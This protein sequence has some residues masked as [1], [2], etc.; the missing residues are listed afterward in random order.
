MNNSTI[1]SKVYLVF[2]AKPAKTCQNVYKNTEDLHS[3][4]LDR[5]TTKSNN[6]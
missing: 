2:T 5:F 3:H 6:I 4:K 1:K